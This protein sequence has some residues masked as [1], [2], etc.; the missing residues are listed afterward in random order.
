MS[1]PVGHSIAGLIFY[2]IAK[3]FAPQTFTKWTSSLLFIALALLPDSDII[4]IKLGLLPLAAH[5]TFTHSVTFAI[6][7]G[8][9]TAYLYKRFKPH[10][11]K[12]IWWLFPAT[13]F[14]H[15]LMDM[16]CLDYFPPYGIQLFWPFSK[17]FIY[18]P[19]PFMTS[20]GTFVALGDPVK[21]ALLKSAS[22][23]VFVMGSLY[24]IILW[25][26]DFYECKN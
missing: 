23:E 10:A 13:I 2:T 12:I 21:I 14:S 19:L 3:R 25:I 18:T 16:S 7:A 9:C 1:S 24:F 17:Q 5:R 8:L 4:F 15:C 20:V 26:L 11:S 6:L 22:M